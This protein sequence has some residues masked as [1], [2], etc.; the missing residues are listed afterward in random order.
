[1]DVRLT[2]SMNS[3]SNYK[4]AICMPTIFGHF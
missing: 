2:L 3:G 1:M 4:K